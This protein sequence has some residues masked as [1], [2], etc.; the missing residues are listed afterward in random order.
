MSEE[1]TDFPRI[2]FMPI[3]QRRW[4]FREIPHLEATLEQKQAVAKYPHDPKFDSSEIANLEALR[5]VI[6]DQA[7]RTVKFITTAPIGQ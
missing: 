4:T 6:Q 7:K 2:D 1:A 5:I 3:N